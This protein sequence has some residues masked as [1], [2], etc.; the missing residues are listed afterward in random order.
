M[1]CIKETVKNGYSIMIGLSEVQHRWI[2][3]R[4]PGTGIAA[5]VSPESNSATSLQCM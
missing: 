2:E 3:C 5:E 1:A 4:L